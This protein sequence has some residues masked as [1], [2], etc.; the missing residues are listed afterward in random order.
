MLKITEAI[1]RANGTDLKDGDALAKLDGVLKQQATAGV[2][3][4]NALQSH[5]P[6]PASNPVF[7]DQ[8]VNGLKN[9]EGAAVTP[10]SPLQSVIHMET[11]D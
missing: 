7:I 8:T 9:H 10:Q 6:G 2:T 5:C 11:E 1:A 4:I 3:I